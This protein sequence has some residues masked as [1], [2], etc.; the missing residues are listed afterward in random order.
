MALRE[1]ALWK[2]LKQALP[3]I[4]LYRIESS[5]TPGFPDVIGVDKKTAE[6]YFIELKAWKSVGHTPQ[7]GNTKTSQRIFHT[8]LR[9]IGA[10]NYILG[11]N[12]VGKYYI[13][14]FDGMNSIDW[15]YVEKLEDLLQFLRKGR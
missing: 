3:D 1:S 4:Q 12:G 8:Q 7:F 14:Q 6:V 11:V 13:G 10:N 5:I 2:S 9:K 15:V